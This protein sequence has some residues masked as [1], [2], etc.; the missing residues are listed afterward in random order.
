[1]LDL[2]GILYACEPTWKARRF[3]N[4]NFCVHSAMMPTEVGKKFVWMRPGCSDFLS[5]LS[6]FVTITIWN[7]MLE[8]TIRDIYNY[9]FGPSLVNPHRILGQEDCD[10]V[11]LRK[12]GNTMFYMKEVGTQK[13]MF[14]KTLSNHLLNNFDDVGLR[15]V[16]FG[17]SRGV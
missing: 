7:S 13:D 1:M 14:L 9:F 10:R 12:V 5:E 15:G 4:T 17:K 3:K 11:L 8:L 16:C 2:N 6:T